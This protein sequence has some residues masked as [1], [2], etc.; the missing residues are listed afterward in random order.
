MCSDNLQ[1]L[2]M[3]SS[4]PPTASATLEGGTS[5]TCAT[6]NSR[7]P[8]Q[9]VNAATSVCFDHSTFSATYS[10]QSPFVSHPSPATVTAR[11]NAVRR[12]TVSNGAGPT[13]ARQLAGTI[14]VASPVLTPAPTPAPEYSVESEHRLIVSSR[15]NVGRPDYTHHPAF[16]KPGSFILLTDTSR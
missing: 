1:S 2:F 9:N 4:L 12:Q 7:I 3:P 11:D 16:I 15:P 10:R 8:T 6:A 14:E 5:I 13:T